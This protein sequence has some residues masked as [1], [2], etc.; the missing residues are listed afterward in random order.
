TVPDLAAARRCVRILAHQRRHVEGY[1]EPGLSAGQ[2]VFVPLVG[3]L[4][5]REARE[6]PHR[7]EPAAIASGGDTAC[8]RELAGHLFRS[9]RQVLG[10]IQRSD[11]HSRERGRFNPVV[12]LR[13][14]LELARP[15]PAEFSHLLLPVSHPH[16]VLIMV[17]PW[18]PRR[19]WPG[20][21]RPPRWRPGSGPLS[22]PALG[23][24]GSG[25]LRRRRTVYGPGAS[26]AT[27]RVRRPAA[28][29]LPPWPTRRRGPPPRL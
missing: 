9:R 20:R 19:Q 11:V 22:A 13:R 25:S 26:D 23:P 17:R 8:V 3:L 24:G 28:G 7:P 18:T 2:Q 16:A 10:R 21:I 27:A 6:L 12:A 29:G 5:R 1:R 15:R 4:G 14:S